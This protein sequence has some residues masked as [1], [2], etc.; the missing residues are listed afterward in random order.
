MLMSRSTPADTRVHCD[1]TCS[2]NSSTMPATRATILLKS[3]IALPPCI[4]ATA[5]SVHRHEALPNSLCTTH[6]D[7]RLFNAC[8][9]CKNHNQLAQVRVRQP[10]EEWRNSSAVPPTTA[11]GAFGYPY[12]VGGD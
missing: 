12:A 3:Q 9:G 6:Y 1:S 10:D 2:L 5:L 4:L 7:M 11:V 8:Y